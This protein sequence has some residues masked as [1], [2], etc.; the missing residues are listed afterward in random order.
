MARDPIPTWY[1]ALV[2]VEHEDRFLIVQE[3]KHGQKWYLPAGRV[4]AGEDFISAARR[5]TLE[6]AGIEVTVQRIVRVEHL[7]LDDGARM[8][9][10]FLARPAAGVSAAEIG[11]PDSLA[12]AWVTVEELSQYSLRDP[13]IGE[14]FRYI[15]LGGQTYPLEVLNRE[16]APY[17][18]DGDG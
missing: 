2:V 17:R 15:A 11:G 7:P 18:V 10:V 9:V 14:L 16:G 13:E 6:E 3:R 1:F 4:E 5:E 8:R 12:A